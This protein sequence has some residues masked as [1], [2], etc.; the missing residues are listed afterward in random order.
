[1]VISDGTPDDLVLD[2]E[3]SGPCWFSGRRIRLLYVFFVCFFELEDT[4][5]KKE[6]MTA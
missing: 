5:Q 2:D 6:L 3:T 1:M 4:W